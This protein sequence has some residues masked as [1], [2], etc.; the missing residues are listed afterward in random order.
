MQW[1]RRCEWRGCVGRCGAEAGQVSAV[2][3]G[4][5]SC[6]PPG[7]PARQQWR[8][9]GC[10]AQFCHAR[11]APC[12]P[13]CSCRW[14]WAGLSGGTPDQGR[15]GAGWL[16]APQMSLRPAS[17]DPPASSRWSPTRP[18][19]GSPPQTSSRLP[20]SSTQTRSQ[21]RTTPARSCYKHFAER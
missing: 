1:W 20:T 15:T 19:C 5:P 14:G 16:A 8:G 11:P 2:Q 9:R 18:A 13:G 7:P 3:A 17:G 21:R 4:L 12:P 6:C 10:T